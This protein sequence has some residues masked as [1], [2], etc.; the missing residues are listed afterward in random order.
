[1]MALYKLLNTII[2]QVCV[3][4]SAL[5]LDEVTT[6]APIWHLHLHLHED[7]T[8]TKGTL[9]FCIDIT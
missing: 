9:M 3:T 8:R 7:C 5:Q 2:F 4:Y 1:M 6:F